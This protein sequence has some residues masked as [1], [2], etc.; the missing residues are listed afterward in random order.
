M[1]KIP[2]DIFTA[3]VRRLKTFGLQSGHEE[4]RSRSGGTSNSEFDSINYWTPDWLASMPIQHYK[5]GLWLYA[6]EANL[7]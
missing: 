3:H 6:D 4:A 2:G 7:Y 5:R 1:K